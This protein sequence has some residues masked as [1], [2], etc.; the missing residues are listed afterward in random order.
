MYNS[1]HCRQMMTG[2]ILPKIYFLRSFSHL[3]LTKKWW[4]PLTYQREPRLSVWR[5]QVTDF[6][7]HEGCGVPVH[8]KSLIVFARLDLHWTGFVSNNFFPI[9][10]WRSPSFFYL[11]LFVAHPKL[12]NGLAE[13]YYKLLNGSTSK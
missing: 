12:K 4:T 9:V 5:S 11:E 7:P 3:S 1:V 8:F 10:T 2:G 13:E 6:L